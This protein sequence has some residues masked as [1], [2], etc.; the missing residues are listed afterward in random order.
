MMFSVVVP[1]YRIPYGMLRRC[2]KSIR[3]QTYPDFELILIDDGS[4]DDCGRICEE[5]AA[6]DSRIRVIHQQN[7][8]LSVVRNVGF[9]RAA[10]DWVC[11]VDADDWLE[12]DALASGAAYLEGAS[13]DIDILICDAYV[14]FDGRREL[15][16]FLGR[17]TD[18]PVAFRGREKER[19]IDLFLPDGGMKTERRVWADIG[20]TWARFYR[21]R[22][23]VEHGLQ[24]TPNLKRMQDNIFNLYAVSEA[25]GIVYV[26]KRIYHYAIR[27]ESAARKYDPHMA[28]TLRML[29]ACYMRF[30]R[31]SGHP[32]YERRVNLKMLHLFTRLLANC[33]AHPDNK[34]PFLK[35]RGDAARAFSTGD[36]RKI[37]LA[38]DASGERVK[39]KALHF[40][41][42]LRL[43]G[44]LLLVSKYNEKVRK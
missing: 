39:I 40:L 11:I 33:F 19:I 23:V 21:R 5:C 15:N 30:V 3:E 6:Q 35:R 18:G 12:P 37:L 8:G 17:E 2:V 25:A 24:N 36:F 7:R 22:F 14:E 41:L 31:D 43:Y 44:V 13:V 1:V 29:Y 42:R 38:C 20:S 27:G 10:G 26:P 32:E 16:C 9:E 28:D 4:P 34:A